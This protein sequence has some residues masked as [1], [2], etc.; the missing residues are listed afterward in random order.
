M[1]CGID[2]RAGDPEPARGVEVHLDRLGDQ[3]VGREQ[4]DLEAVGDLERL[5]LD[6]GVGI[7][8]HLQV[9][10]SQAGWANPSIDADGQQRDETTRRTRTS[11]IT[12]KPLQ[13]EPHGRGDP[14]DLIFVRHRN[15][16]LSN[17]GL[18]G[19]HERIELRYLDGI[20]ALFMLAKAEQVSLVLRT[21]SIKIQQILFLDCAVQCLRLCEVRSVG[22]CHAGQPLLCRG[23]TDVLTR[24]LQEVLSVG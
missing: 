9:A 11:L 15:A 17:P 10:H 3:R 7:G 16:Q 24:D 18:F 1:I 13:G 21:P 22:Q 2:L 5:P 12:T 19:G 20:L 4:V 23:S 14:A 8:D 6:L